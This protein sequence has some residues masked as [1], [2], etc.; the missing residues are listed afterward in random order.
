MS[1]R[2]VEPEQTGSVEY[3][4]DLDEVVPD[5]IYDAIVAMDDFADGFVAKLR[6]DTP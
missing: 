1:S 2:W 4:D 3:G 5:A 6:H